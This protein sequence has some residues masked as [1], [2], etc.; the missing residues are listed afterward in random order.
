MVRESFLWELLISFGLKRVF[1]AR[2]SSK[3]VCVFPFKAPPGKILVFLWFAKAFIGFHENSSGFLWFPFCS[4]LARESG[5]ASGRERKGRVSIGKPWLPLVCK[6]FI[7]N[8]RF[9]FDLKG[10]HEK[11]LLY[12]RF[13]ES[14][15]IAWES[16][17][18]RG[19]KGSHW[20]ASV[21]LW[22]ERFSIR[23]LRFSFGLQGFHKKYFVL[24][25]FA[26]AS[27]G[28]RRIFICFHIVS[29]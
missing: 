1:V 16:T 23:Y 28:N 5:L 2:C 19:K 12:L 14:F 22:F 24:P 10:L 27:I 9:S 13:P 26:T 17:S 3:I 11:S 8:Q 7:R 20:Q 21:L 4:C 29:V 15:C 6:V 25:R 18:A